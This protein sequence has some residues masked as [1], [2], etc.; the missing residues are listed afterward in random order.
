M[1]QNS[2]PFCTLKP[3]RVW[4]ENE[5]GFGVY[6]EF[7]ITEGHSLVVPKKHVSSIFD[8]SMVE[9]AALWALVNEV[10]SD[11]RRKCDTTDFNVGINDGPSAG[12]TVPHAHIHVIPRRPGDVTDPRGG[13]RWII[14]EKAKYW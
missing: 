2:C 6:D 14:P 9:Q 10:R 7:P 12:Q 5:V 11:L 4:A 1:N 3:T 8:L 13:I